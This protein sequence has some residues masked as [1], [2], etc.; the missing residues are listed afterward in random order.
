MWGEQLVL[1]GFSLTLWRHRFV[2]AGRKRSFRL[3]WRPGWFPS[4]GQLCFFP[5]FASV[6]QTHEDLG[7]PPWVQA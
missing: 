2:A 4:G 5:P 6:R 1:F 3:D 7:L